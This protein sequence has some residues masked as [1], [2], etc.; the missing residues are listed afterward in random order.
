MFMT[1]FMLMQQMIVVEILLVFGILKLVDFVLLKQ[2]QI[3]RL[4]EHVQLHIHL[5]YLVNH[6]PHHQ[7]VLNHQQVQVINHLTGRREI[8]QKTLVQPAVGDDLRVFHGAPRL[9]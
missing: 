4:L 1:T 9:E 6:Q 2:V 3:V 5:N 7:Q 8:G